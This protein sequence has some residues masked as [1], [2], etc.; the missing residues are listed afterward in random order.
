[1]LYLLESLNI[2]DLIGGELFPI[3]A[4]KFVAAQRCA[5]HCILSTHLLGIEPDYP[6]SQRR[7]NR[8]QGTL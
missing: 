5:N 7:Q 6:A 8:A 3:I 2:V 1:M 4:S